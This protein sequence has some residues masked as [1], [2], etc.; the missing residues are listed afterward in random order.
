MLNKGEKYFAIFVKN[1][2]IEAYLKFQA[3]CIHE[4]SYVF[5]TYFLSTCVKC[6]GMSIYKI[7]NKNEKLNIHDTITIENI[8][9]LQKPNI[10]GKS[11]LY[12]M[13]IKM[14]YKLVFI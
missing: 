12:S 3:S 1:F 8:P 11:G 7:Q 10:I 14:L 13:I 6:I 5:H 2:N 4:Y 9:I